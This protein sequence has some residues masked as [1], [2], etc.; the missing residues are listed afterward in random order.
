MFV[1]AVGPRN[2]AFEDRRL[3]HD[4]RFPALAAYIRAHYPQVAEIKGCRIYARNDRLP[5]APQ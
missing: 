5:A 2:I 3:A 4:A 1:D